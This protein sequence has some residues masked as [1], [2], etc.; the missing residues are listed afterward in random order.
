MDKLYTDLARK[1]S[2]TKRIEPSGMEYASVIQPVITQ[3]ASYLDENNLSPTEDIVFEWM[4]DN[5]VPKISDDQFDD[6]RHFLKR[7]ASSL[8]PDFGLK[9]LFISQSNHF[10][11]Y[12][13]LPEWGQ[14]MI[15][16][17]CFY[18][19]ITGRYWTEKTTKGVN[20]LLFLIDKSFGKAGV[21]IDCRI[22][23]AYHIEKGKS[24]R[25]VIEFIEFLES[26]GFATHYAGVAY[27]SYFAPRVSI[28]DNVS[29]EDCEDDFSIEEYREAS[30]KLIKAREEAGYSISAITDISSS[31]AE[32]GIFLEIQGRGFSM[33]A[34][35]TFIN[36]E[37]QK[38]RIA[39][40]TRKRA[41]NEVKDILCGKDFSNFSRIYYPSRASM[42]SWAKDSF[43]AYREI[44]TKNRM[45]ESTL[46]M[47][48]SSLLK[49]CT[50]LDNIGITSFSEVTQQNIK[51][52][53]LQDKHYSAEGKAAYNHRIKGFLKFLYEEKITEQNLSLSLSAVAA[54]KIKPPIILSEEEETKLNDYLDTTDSLL[55]KALLKI[56]SQTGMRSIDIVN[57]TF[58]SIDW[59]NRVFKIVQQ[60]TKV[61]TNIPFT[62]GV[63]NALYEYITEERPR[64][65][66]NFI[67]ITPKAPFVP[68]SK[69]VVRSALG[70]AL[71]KSKGAHILRK[72]FASKM[73]ASSLVFSTVT[74]ALGHTTDVTLDP[75]ISI[76]ERRLKACALPLGETF[77]YKGG[78][79]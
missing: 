13:S 34:V 52:F 12:S 73:I 67:F 46:R 79:M 42:P 61:E 43:N 69:N 40:H 20:F 49:F 41:L 11:G 78:L 14:K 8:C 2:K 3:M 25:G 58:D 35:N 38:V 22:T 63:G 30:E 15:D 77:A 54:V 32:F 31:L 48:Y 7:I 65:E 27:N 21:V 60:K 47:D 24:Q 23:S 57:L 56:A 74:D 6:V 64:T 1:L 37:E 76:D 39:S 44:R 28:F 26:A 70:R 55:D 36:V 33:G 53:N 17:F 16:E 66:N 29:I 19:L 10:I 5:A 50:Y 75:Y 68:Y 45:T 18:L 59:D 9:P 71:G 51:D 72:T 62:N 4:K